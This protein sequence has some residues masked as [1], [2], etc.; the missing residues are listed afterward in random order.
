MTDY[1]RVIP[2]SLINEPSY[3]LRFTLPKTLLSDVY[4]FAVDK[5]K[6][7]ITD[8]GNEIN[9]LYFSNGFEFTK[10]RRTTLGAKDLFFVCEK[11]ES[12]YKYKEISIFK[13]TS[14]QEFAFEENID[15]CYR[16]ISNRLN[17]NPKYTANY[18]AIFTH[19]RGMMLRIERFYMSNFFTVE[20][21]KQIDEAYEL[22]TRSDISN[23]AFDLMV[24][25]DSKL[26]FLKN[27]DVSLTLSASHPNKEK[28]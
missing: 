4:T 26:D 15:E 5:C 9:K 19:E 2:R 1:N 18:T 25:V 7:N 10:L 14:K 21:E 3:S 11:L 13:K 12:E 8:L 24:E 27:L 16:A 23:L 6:M 20:F 22:G 17:E 28:E